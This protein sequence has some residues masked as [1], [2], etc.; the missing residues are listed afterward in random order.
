MS[1]E[2]IQ[3]DHG[4]SPI[5]STEDSGKVS[6]L[7]QK[8]DGDLNKSLKALFG[9]ACSLG[10]AHKLAVTLAPHF[11]IT[12]IEFLSKYRRWKKGQL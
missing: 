10:T 11:G 2:K 9:S 8:Y 12:T 3:P 4:S 7:L 6:A 1:D 5:W